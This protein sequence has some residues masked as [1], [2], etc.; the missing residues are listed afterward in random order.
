LIKQN[1]FLNKIFYSPFGYK[2][3]EIFKENKKTDPVKNAKF[4]LKT[5]LQHTFFLFFGQFYLHFASKFCEKVL[6]G[7]F[8][9]FYKNAHKKVKSNP[10][11]WT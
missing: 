4:M 6:I 3:S 9:K 1:K 7:P 2:D 11:W 5:V 10:I 8:K